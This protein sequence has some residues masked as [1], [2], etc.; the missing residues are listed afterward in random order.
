MTDLIEDKEAL[1]LQKTGKP[2]RDVADRIALNWWSLGFFGLLVANGWLV[3]N[4]NVL[5][6]RAASNLQIEYVRLYPNG[7]SERGKYQHRAV[8]DFLPNTV[9]SLLKHY[10]QIRYGVRPATITADYG[11]VGMFLSDAMY[12]DFSK[13]EE[14]G[15]YDAA[16]KA[17]A[18]SI[19]PEEKNRVVIE[20][21][22]INHYDTVKGVINNRSSEVV[23]TNIYYTK[24]TRTPAGTEVSREAKVLPL[25]WH[26]I[27]LDQLEKLAAKNDTILDVNPLGLE[28]IDGAEQVDP[29]GLGRK[30][31]DKK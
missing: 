21:I 5:S 28:I 19:K 11:E 7:T 29:A 9:D 14:K 12:N 10:V 25:Q 8:Q 17:A 13:P 30:N 6:E 24:V 1:R 4:N 2:R 20:D 22:W 15:G 23:R 18:L 26:F 31:G 16:K 3:Y 27:P